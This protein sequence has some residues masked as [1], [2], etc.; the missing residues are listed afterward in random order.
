MRRSCRRIAF[1]APL[2]DRSLMTL[3]SV[4]VLSPCIGLCEIAADGLCEGCH[5]SL[6]EIAH[7]GGLP[8]ASRRR[9]MDEVLPARAALREEG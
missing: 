4:P 5:R 9:L 7:W 1:G 2:A 6:D 8:E 3:P